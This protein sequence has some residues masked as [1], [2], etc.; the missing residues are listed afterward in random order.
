[1]TTDP[2]CL[3]QLE[4]GGITPALAH[5]TKNIVRVHQQHPAVQQGD[6]VAL[7]KGS[8]DSPPWL[9][10][11]TIVQAGTW[12]PSLDPQGTV[13]DRQQ[14][15]STK[16]LSAWLTLYDDVYAQGLKFS[17]AEFIKDNSEGFIAGR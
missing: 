11:N 12:W 9:I 6:L 1:M 3:A 8:T 13:L 10:L 14:L 17:R 15:I 2:S 7:S 16:A 5:A 4:L